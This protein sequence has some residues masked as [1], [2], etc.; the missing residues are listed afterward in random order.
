MIASLPRANQ[1]TVGPPAVQTASGGVSRIGLSL[2]IGLFLLAYNPAAAQS[3]Q[4]SE[5]DRGPRQER[6]DQRPGS[7][8]AQSPSSLPSW[9]EPAPP[10]Q[11]ERSPTSENMRTRPGNVGTRAPAPPD[12]PSRIPVDGGLALLAAAGAGYA[13][14]KLN[15]E[16]DDEDPVA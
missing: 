10:S 12:N 3:F 11:E 6:L 14:R 9:A 16:D 5:Q 7:G 2:A 1:E 15:E 4:D 13:V 8:P